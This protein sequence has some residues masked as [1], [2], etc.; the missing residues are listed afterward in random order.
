MTTRNGG[1]CTQRSA[2]HPEASQ[3]AYRC[4]RCVQ[5]EFSDMCYQLWAWL[6]YQFCST[7]SPWSECVWKS[8]VSKWRGITT[9]CT[10]DN[11]PERC[12]M[13]NSNYMTSHKDD[14]IRK[15]AFSSRYSNELTFCTIHVEVCNNLKFC[16]NSRIVKVSMRHHTVWCNQI[17][18]L[19]GENG[20]FPGPTP[21]IQI[22]EFFKM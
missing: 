18:P 4:E 9:L 8:V 19:F 1:N 7:W 6:L 22:N 5:S 15:P 17:G 3:N 2:K 11:T 14:K 10:S 12:C 20:L 13:L 16:S 21:Q